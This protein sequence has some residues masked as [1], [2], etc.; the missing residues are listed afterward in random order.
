MLKN[1]SNSFK[2]IKNLNQ[3]F[4]R[5]ITSGDFLNVFTFFHNKLPAFWEVVLT[6]KL[7]RLDLFLELI[8]SCCNQ[9]SADRH[10]KVQVLKR[11]EGEG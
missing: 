6:I 7:D 4:Y 1:L 8:V 11:G 2:E 3:L 5:N 9:N 10:S